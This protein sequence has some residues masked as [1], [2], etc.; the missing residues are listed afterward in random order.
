M[1]TRTSRRSLRALALRCRQSG[2][3]VLPSIKLDPFAMASLSRS[4][5]STLQ[6]IAI[7]RRNPS[8]CHRQTRKFTVTSRQS[9]TR[10]DL[11]K[12]APK[13]QSANTRMKQLKKSE[14]PSDIGL[15]P[16][17]FIRP[18]WKEGPSLLSSKWKER[19]IMDWVHIRQSAS[20][21]IA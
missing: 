15:I 20:D 19:L 21:L 5:P 18:T 17:T 6:A 12:I 8:Q 13:Q 7:P 1:Y 14:I 16:G 9:A 11:A 10:F 2:S 3:P 4:G